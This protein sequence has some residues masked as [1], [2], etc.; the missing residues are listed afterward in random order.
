M[1]P[2]PALG[3]PQTNQQRVCAAVVLFA[4]Q[5]GGGGRQ[6]SH[7]SS[8]GGVFGDAFQPSGPLPGAGGDEGGANTMCGEGA[9]PQPIRVARPK[10]GLLAVE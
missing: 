4:G 6:F 5:Q 1:L 3:P 2:G 10:P 8:A 9:G 7:G